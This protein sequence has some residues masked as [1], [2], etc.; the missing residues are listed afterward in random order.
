MQS[1]RQFKQEKKSC[2]SSHTS[3]SPPRLSHF[4]S[5]C[6]CLTFC[7]N[8]RLLPS[9]AS[10]RRFTTGFGLAVR[11]AYLNLVAAC[12]LIGDDWDWRKKL[13]EFGSRVVRGW[14]GGETD[15]AR[16]GDD[17]SGED[18]EGRW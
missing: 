2:Q 13:I 11:L 5:S 16:M 3:F 7:K 10:S 15:E 17:E 8:S 6:L 4:S 18:T 14:C 1:I 12:C 9:W